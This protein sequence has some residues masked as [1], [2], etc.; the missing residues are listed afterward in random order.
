LHEAAATAI[1]LE[2]P[3]L[4]RRLFAAQ[5]ADVSHQKMLAPS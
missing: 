4:D 5:R 1:A 3:I 2:L